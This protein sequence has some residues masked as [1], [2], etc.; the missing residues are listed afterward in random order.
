[1]GFRGRVLQTIS[2]GQCP[3]GVLETYRLSCKLPRGFCH[4]QVT[5]IDLAGN[6]QSKVAG[7]KIAA[8]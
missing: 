3:T 6:T 8:R 1:V 7:A 4:V 5:A 2:L